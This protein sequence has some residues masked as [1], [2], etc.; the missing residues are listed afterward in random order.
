MKEEKEVDALLWIK[1]LKIIGI[2]LVIILGMLVASGILF[3]AA[4]VQITAP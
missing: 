1:I 2:A 4:V 3:N